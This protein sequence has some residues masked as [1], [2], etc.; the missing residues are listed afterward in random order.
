MSK[1]FYSDPLWVYLL[2]DEVKRKKVLKKFF[3][4]L[5]SVGISNNQVYGVSNLLK[6]VLVWEKPDSTF[7]LPWKI[8]IPVLVSL[9]GI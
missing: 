9:S 5:L 1:A 8:L 7:N 2:P 4:I 6:G 3:E